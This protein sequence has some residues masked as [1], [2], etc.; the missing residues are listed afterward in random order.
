MIILIEFNLAYNYGQLF[1]LSM[2][3]M[4]ALHSYTDY[5]NIKEEIRRYLFA[6]W[7]FYG[8]SVSVLLGH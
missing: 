6:G 7:L 1:Y 4:N 3:V 5:M 8:V 2:Y